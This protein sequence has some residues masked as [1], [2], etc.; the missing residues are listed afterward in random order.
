MGPVTVT[1]WRYRFL[2]P[3]F[4][5]QLASGLLLTLTESVQRPATVTRVSIFVLPVFGVTTKVL[6]PE[7]AV[8]A[9]RRRP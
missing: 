8:Q 2:L 9:R 4:H 3:A 1:F 6:P 5:V 7:P